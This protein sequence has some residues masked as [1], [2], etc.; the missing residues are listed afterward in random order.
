[1]HLFHLFSFVDD[2]SL[3]AFKLL[4]QLTVSKKKKA[5]CLSHILMS[6]K[7]HDVHVHEYILR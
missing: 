5:E 1:M 3:E 6:V 7:V 2:A 4:V